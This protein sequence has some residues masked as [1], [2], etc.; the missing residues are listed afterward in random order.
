M[1]SKVETS[2]IERGGQEQYF[3]HALPLPLPTSSATRGGADTRRA[4]HSA[5]R[6]STSRKLSCDEERRVRASSQ[7][8]RLSCHVARS[9]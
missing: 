3:C 2:F 1:E 9:M 5:A 8:R 4:S 7:T 6:V